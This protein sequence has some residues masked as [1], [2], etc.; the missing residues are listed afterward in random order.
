MLQSNLFK[1]ITFN[2]RDKGIVKTLATNYLSKGI[3]FAA[4]LVIVPLTLNYLGAE[5]YGFFITLITTLGWLLLFDFGVGNSLKNLI[6][7]AATRENSIE[8]SR[9]YSNGLLLLGTVF[10]LFSLIAFAVTSFIPWARVFNIATIAEHDLYLIVLTSILIYLLNMMLALSAN[11]YY[12][13]Q[14]G[15][16]ANIFGAMGNLIGLFCIYSAIQAHASIHV[17]ILCYLLGFII[18]NTASY[19][20]LVFYDKKYLKFHLRLLDKKI[21]K[22]IMSL[23]M[24]FW[25]TSIIATILFSLDN[26]MITQFLGP[27]K[28]AEY[29]PI[30]RL[31]QIIIQANGLLFISLWPAYTDA[32]ARKDWIWIKHSLKR[33][34]KMIVYLFLPFV[35]VLMFFGPEIIKIWA[36]KKIIPSHSLCIMIGIWTIVFM[37]N[38]TLAAFLNGASI[39]GKQV[40]YG[41]VCVVIFIVTGIVLIKAYGLIGLSIAGTISV[42]V[43]L[44][45]NPILIHN[46]F[47]YHAGQIKHGVQYEMKNS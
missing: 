15:Y 1:K 20:Y 26:I 24:A 38:Q 13:F 11:I 3:N 41:I 44:I 19:I 10:I 34:L 28:I 6:A 2:E 21:L 39:M 8:L 12:G 9:I 14:Q 30:M 7:E 27:E 40:K 32:I 45:V 42:S 25:G 29:N 23:G 31:F 22:R 5:N 37:I 35:L 43:G 47:K 16:I 46:F 4:N 36:S 33:S 17:L 18:A